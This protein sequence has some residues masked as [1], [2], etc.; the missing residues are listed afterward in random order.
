MI[1]LPATD[2]IFFFSRP[3]STAAGQGVIF[4]DKQPFQI[5][6]YTA[7]LALSPTH[8]C[9][10]INSRGYSV[11]CAEIWSVKTTGQLRLRWREQSLWFNLIRQG[12]TDIYLIKP[13]FSQHCDKNVTL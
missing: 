5:F 1:E 3:F 9:F 6:P 10:R 11:S 7:D 2:Y 4:A 12:T 8:V 13:F